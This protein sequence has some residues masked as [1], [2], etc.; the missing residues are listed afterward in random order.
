MIP[1]KIKKTISLNSFELHKI[2]LF[3]EVNILFKLLKFIQ[4]KGAHN[5]GNEP[6]IKPVNINR[7]F[8]LIFKT[9][10]YYFRKGLNSTITPNVIEKIL[11]YILKNSLGLKFI[12]TF[13]EFWITK[14]ISL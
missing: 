5:L 9:P 4:F 6:P 12:K 7:V 2:K 11:K 10:N 8:L 1:I 3:F 14:S 13:I